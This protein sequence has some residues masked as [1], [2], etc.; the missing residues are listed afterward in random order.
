LASRHFLQGPFC[1][2]STGPF[3]ATRVLAF[4][5]G[6]RRVDAEEAHPCG[7]YVESIAVYNL[8]S[9]DDRGGLRAS[10]LKIVEN[11]TPASTKV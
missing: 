3:R 5:G 6:F 8:G 1:R 7:A 2:A 9:A 11:T 10:D 4:L